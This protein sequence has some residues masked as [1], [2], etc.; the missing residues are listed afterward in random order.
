MKTEFGRIPEAQYAALSDGYMKEQT[1]LKQKLEKGQNHLA[2][3][4]SKIPNTARFV[5]NAKKYT[6]IPELTSEILHTFIQRIEIGA[7]AE[8]KARYTTQEIRI[9]YRDVGILDNIPENTD[10]I[11]LYTSTTHIA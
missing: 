9:I 3:L 7:R 10:G 6:E 2:E 4:K 11:E 1:D 8:K 5:A